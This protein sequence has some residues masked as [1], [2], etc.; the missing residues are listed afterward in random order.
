MFES[1][2]ITFRPLDTDDASIFYQ[3][4]KDKQVTQYSLSSFAYPQSKTDISNWLL[5][6]NNTDKSVSF[7][8][9]CKSSGRLIG[10]A[11]IASISALNRCGEYFILIG[12]KEYWGKGIGTEITSC[13]TQYG[14]E[15]L[16]LH[17]IELTAFSNNQGAIKAYTKAGYQKEGVMRQAAIET[18]ASTTRY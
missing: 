17:R 12:N 8:V 7:G 1:E 14:F 2:R 5:T 13:V 10:Y 18:V 3:W 15:T 16:G 9:C 6:I 11:G 4:A